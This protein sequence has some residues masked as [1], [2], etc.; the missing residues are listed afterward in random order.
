MRD[1]V[2]GRW[3]GAADADY[4]P[5]EPPA[6]PA[7]AWQTQLSVEAPGEGGCVDDPPF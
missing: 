4:V 5:M 1:A 6:T 3:R 2:T 7:R